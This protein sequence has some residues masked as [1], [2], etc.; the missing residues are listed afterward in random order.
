M[1]VRYGRGAGGALLLLL[2]V[3][4]TPRFLALRRRYNEAGQML[5]E[6]LGGDEAARELGP[7]RESL[8][9]RRHNW[10]DLFQ[11]GIRRA[12]DVSFFL[13]ILDSRVGR[14]HGV[15]SEK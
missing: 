1:D 3:P 8:A 13:G 4:E 5:E 11:P 2:R 10:R 9:G 6:I 14:E 15:W 7:I 12:I